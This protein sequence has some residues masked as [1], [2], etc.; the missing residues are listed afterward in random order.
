[1]LAVK[2][3]CSPHHPRPLTDGW[4]IREQSLP[5]TNWETQM[6]CSGLPGCHDSVVQTLQ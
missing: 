4:L 1:M 3:H 5:S 6:V 2:K